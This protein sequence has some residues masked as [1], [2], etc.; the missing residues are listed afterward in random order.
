MK[1]L[2]GPTLKANFKT[3]I[4][5]SGR[6]NKTGEMAEDRPEPGNRHKS[7]RVIRLATATDTGQ[8][9]EEGVG[10]EEP[11]CPQWIYS[12]KETHDAFTA[13][14]SSRVSCFCDCHKAVQG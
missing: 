6:K 3:I 9:G 10:R 8:G 14:L 4:C 12:L 13:F 2:R 1:S 5:H 7:P 11:T